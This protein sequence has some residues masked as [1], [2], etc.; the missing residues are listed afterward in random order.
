MRPFHFHPDA[1]LEADQA[2]DFYEEQKRGLGKRFI[3]SLTDA[4]NRIRRNPRLY[5]KV[6]DNIQKCR[7]LRFPYGIIYRDKDDSIEIIAV[8]HFK[9]KPFYWKKRLE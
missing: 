8:M 4:I 2:A 9:R 6:F 1:L 3:E 7:I 5:P